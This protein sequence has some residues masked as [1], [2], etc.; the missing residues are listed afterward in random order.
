MCRA[1]RW[2]RNFGR[3]HILAAIA[4]LQ[5]AACA[6]TKLVLHVAKRIGEA[7]VDASS[8]EPPPVSGE[9]IRVGKPYQVKEVWYY[10]KRQPDYD[11]TGIAS[12]YGEKF[13]GRRT[14]NGEIYDMNALTAAHK[15]LP[16]PTNVRV[17]NL[18]N[19]RSMI[20]RV[21]DRGP[22]AHGRIIDVSRRAAQLLG[23][24]GAGTAKVRV[25]AM[26]RGEVKV[27]DR[28]ET[29]AAE[30]KALPALPRKG[31]QSQR[32]APPPGTRE[33]RARLRDGASVTRVAA[34]PPRSDALLAR[35]E[36]SVAVAVQP[37]KPTRIFIQAGS[38]I[39]YDNA[40]RLR[41]RLAYLG[42]TKIKAVWVREREFFRVR[43]GPVQTV[44][45]ADGI[46]DSVIAKG[47]T[48]ARIIVD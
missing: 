28:A 14:A 19:G 20:L 45:R 8:G 10:P 9:K 2:H 5:L 36:P 4:V 46:L 30:R 38:F 23:F 32:L 15:T 24:Q 16:L 26:E 39:K 34:A 13:H 3:Y 44:E 7:G 42:P 17:T 6:E 27:A 21:N 43:V 37:V 12:W 25:Q 29:T 1:K 40:H 11:E 48:D 22:F 18:T 31:V 47:I 35:D 33:A 41:A